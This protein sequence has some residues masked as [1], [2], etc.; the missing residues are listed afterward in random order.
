MRT[1]CA[2]V[3]A[4]SVRIGS[5]FVTIDNIKYGSYNFCRDDSKGGIFANRGAR[6]GL[7]RGSL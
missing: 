1:T 6:F 5:V 7:G 4:P 2:I 3:R